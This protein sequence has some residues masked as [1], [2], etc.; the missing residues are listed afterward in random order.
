MAE[1]GDLNQR[2]EA[3]RTELSEKIDAI[4]AEL[5]SAKVWALSVLCIA[6]YLSLLFVMARAGSGGFRAPRG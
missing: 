5:S 1:I 2:I 3:V 6:L 4:R